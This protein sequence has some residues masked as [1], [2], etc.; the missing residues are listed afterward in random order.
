MLDFSHIRLGHEYDRKWLA[1]H[2][3][4]ESFHPLAKGVFCPRGGGQIILFVTKEKQKTQEQY[5][6]YISDGR[7]YW[8]GE[9]KHG[10]DDRIES[11][12]MNGEEI[13]LFY[14]DIHVAPFEYKGLVELVSAKR[15]THKSSEFVFRL[16]S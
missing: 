12:K 6:D 15:L 1:E 3:G 2:W 10:T 11:S 5:N 7:L 13:H 4:F 9:I 8:E 16:I 14:R